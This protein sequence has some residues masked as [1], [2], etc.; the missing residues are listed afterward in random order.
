MRYKDIHIGDVHE[1]T[2]T[3]TKQDVGLFAELSGD[4]NKIH[5]DE[6]YSKKT[7]FKKNIVHG[8]FAGMLFST[9]IGMH[10]PGENSLYLSQTL[11]FAH[12]I[13]PNDTVIVRGTIIHKNDSIKVITIKMEIHVNEK[14]AVFGE[15]KVKVI[16]NEK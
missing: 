12:P 14:I 9:F 15:A 1:F 11:N 6:E 3:I 5:V 10:C 4:Y 8:M 13:F 2:R 7:L 16:Y